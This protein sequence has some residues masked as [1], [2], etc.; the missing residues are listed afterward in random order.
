SKDFPP[1]NKYR[2]P[3][4]RHASGRGKKVKTIVLA[5][6]DDERRNTDPKRTCCHEYRSR[7]YRVLSSSSVSSFVTSSR[8]P[9][10]G[11]LFNAILGAQRIGGLLVHV[12]VD[13]AV[14]DFKLEALSKRYRV[15]F[16]PR[17]LPKDF[18]GKI[19]WDKSLRDCLGSN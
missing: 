5:A 18:G 3:A 9:Y 17:D 4:G 14:E 16:E 10:H 19:P 11:S 8:P 6:R 15:L 2:S 7:T 1:R 12:G 13:V